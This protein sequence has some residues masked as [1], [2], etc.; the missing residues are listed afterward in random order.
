MGNRGEGSGGLQRRPPSGDSGS[1]VVISRQ[2]RKEG[3]LRNLDRANHFHPLL[4]G[5]LLLQQLPLAG[6]VA[7]VSLGGDVLAQGL[8]GLARDDATADGGLQRDLEHLPRDQL[9]E[10]LDDVATAIVGRVLVDDD[11][12]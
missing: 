2:Y 4:T 6:D 8:D 3:F 7:T 11:T 9:L 5:L 1:V 12:E 10:R